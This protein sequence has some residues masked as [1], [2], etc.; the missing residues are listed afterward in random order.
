MNINLL[1]KKILYKSMYRGTREND[2]L[3]RNFC[4][5]YIVNLNDENEIEKINDFL[6]LPDQ[7]IFQT[8][9]EKNCDIYQK[10]KKIFDEMEKIKI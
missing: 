2:F 1:K 10:Y 7:I 9:K 4:K 3:I 8:L 6:D 5:N